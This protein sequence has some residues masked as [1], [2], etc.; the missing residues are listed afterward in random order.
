[1]KNSGRACLGLLFLSTILSSSASAG[2]WVEERNSVASDEVAEGVAGS[3]LVE[4]TRKI[5]DW[6]EKDPMLGSMP[7]YR[8]QLTIFTGYP[9]RDGAPYTVSIQ[10]GFHPRDVWEGNCGLDQGM[11][12][13]QLRAAVNIQINSSDILAFSDAAQEDSPLRPFPLP[14]QKGQNRALPIYGK[15]GFLLL[16]PV[17]TDILLPYT[18]EDHLTEWKARLAEIAMNGGAEFASQQM[19]DIDDR[20]ASLSGEELSQQTGYSGQSPDN[21]MWAYET[22]KGGASTPRVYLNPVLYEEGSDQGDPRFASVWLDNS[23]GDKE[24]QAMMDKWLA[25]TDF[26]PIIDMLTGGGQ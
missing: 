16:A 4:A 3:R 23:T 8:Q 18:V 9:S 14:K 25:R 21:P 26:S 22:V 19:W 6:L 2:C 13:Y 15:E 5:A 11:A 24:L 12:D 17:G 20:L 10:L 1:M 7:G